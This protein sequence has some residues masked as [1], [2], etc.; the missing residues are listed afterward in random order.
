MPPTPTT[1]TAATPAF[2]KA[3]AKG[4]F[5]QSRNAPT[6][7]MTRKQSRCVAQGLVDTFGTD[8]LVV[9]GLSQ[10]QGALALDQLGLTEDEAGSFVDVFSSCGVITRERL[11]ASVKEG[12]GEDAKDPK[13]LACVDSSIDDVALRALMID[14]LLRRG[15]DA[16]S[17]K[18]LQ[19][20]LVD[21]VS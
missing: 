8:R 18:D 14:Q 11:I 20:K 16:P 7:S 21:C 5:R 1:T 15:D 9:W 6:W 4:M 3:V 19:D 2:I 17:S 12:L 13:L 10:R